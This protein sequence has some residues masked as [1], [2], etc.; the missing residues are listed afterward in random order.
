MERRWLVGGCGLV[1]S[2]M[3]ALVAL[4][5]QAG[6]GGVKVM[7]SDKV[8]SYLADASGKTLYTF[9]KDTPGKSAC[10]GD[11]LAK[12]PAFHA[13]KVSAPEGVDASAFSNITRDDGK[14]QTA[15]K[16][17]PLYYFAGDKGP[18]DTSGNGVR[19]VW[20]VAKP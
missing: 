17:K 1:V 7:K 6:G 19:D 5:A 9:K 11:C 15:Y 3:V 16:G 4:P 2:I 10:V 14:A 20:D 13:D 8:G 18:G 12:W